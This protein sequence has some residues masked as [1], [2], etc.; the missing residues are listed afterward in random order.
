M[1]DEFTENEFTE[2]NNQESEQI[3]NQPKETSEESQEL[4]EKR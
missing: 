2:P 4:Y 1:T 3:E